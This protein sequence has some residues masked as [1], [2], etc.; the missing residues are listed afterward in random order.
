MTNIESPADC[1]DSRGSA[2]VDGNGNSSLSHSRR[3]LL[4][5]LPLGGSLLLAG[6]S[7]FT[8]G[9]SGNSTSSPRHT[10]PEQSSDV[11]NRTLRLPIR[12]ND[13]AKTTFYQL[14]P[15]AA[16]STLATETASTRLSRFVWEPGVWANDIWPT[17]TLEYLW[18]DTIEKTP[19][20]LTVS[21]GED[22]TW[23][24]GHRITGKD[25]ATPVFDV[26]LHRFF[27]PF[28]ASDRKDEPSFI[29]GAFDDFEIGDRSVTYRSSE[30]FFENFWLSNAATWLGGWFLRAVPTHI[31]PYARFADALIE[32]VRGA[33]QGEFNPWESKPWEKNSAPTS[34]GLKN[35]YLNDAT[36]AVKF[37]KAENVL[38]TGAW[39]L[40][41]F[42]G[43]EA[44]VFRK[45]TH[46]RNAELIDFDTVLFEY[47][48]SARRKQASLQA[49]RLDYAAGVMPRSVVDS[50]PA[51]MSQLLVPGGWLTGN[52]LGVNFDH[53]A[54]GTRRVRTAIM[55]ALDHSAIA[56]NIHPS[57]AKPVTTPG[58][59]CWDATEYVSQAWID[60]N[61]I[62]YATDREKAGQLMRDAGYTRD[63][64]S[65]WVDADGEPIT[66]T[67]GT[68][69]S[70]PKWEPTVA[71]QLNEFG[72]EATLE[73]VDETAFEDGVE[74]GKY[75]LW[76]SGVKSS[77][78]LAPYL[79]RIWRLAATNPD[80]FGIYPTEQFESG[81]FSQDGTP[82]PQTEERYR[83]FTIKA[84]PVG[85]PAGP[86]Q[87]YHPA[88]LALMYWTNPPEPEFRRRV[89]IGMWLENWYLPIL[90]INKTLQQH[91][92]DDTHWQ[93]PKET[94]SWENFTNGGS[95]SMAGIVASGA[96]R[97]DPD[98]PE[99][100]N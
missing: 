61:L 50:L 25:I 90:P 48:P 31:E 17:G 97:A 67:L 7:R 45:N 20:E 26:H 76:D 99:N 28:Y 16:L 84:P 24:D 29:F 33:Q 8:S 73:R 9:K 88:A 65:W 68:A 89:K 82:L 30:G 79:I 4:Q 2:N 86:L 19:S 34:S 32:T 52:E 15:K 100:T 59:D 70:T 83:V 57:T 47:T 93:W 80:K 41:E 66:V 58:G 40:A 91:F 77:T 60:E 27:R 18:I 54:L 37:S 53:P 11:S 10:S 94:P 87:E 78:N 75:S 1:E 74:R 63:G 72:I 46:H 12:G 62:T 36:Y 49:D 35:E 85:Q 23:S 51:S 81:N 96:V 95:R 22:A 3:S 92:I 6:C 43:S 39:D 42:R 13:P 64:G 55:Y 21:I 98:N 14:A 38:S 44:F 69:S 56:A 5:T 71:S